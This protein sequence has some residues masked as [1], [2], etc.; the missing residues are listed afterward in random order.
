M[1]FV[2]EKYVGVTCKV[3]EENGVSLKPSL[4]NIDVKKLNLYDEK[5]INIY[6]NQKYLN[7]Y[8]KLLKLVVRFL[9]VED[10]SDES[11]ELVLSEISRIE[12]LL[13]SEYKD[14]VSEAKLSEMLKELY[15][16]G[17]KI[18]RKNQKKVVY[19]DEKNKAR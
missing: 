11:T 17:R 14:F 7:K 16:L 15:N 3:F 13:L 1:E 19:M 6:L 5:I 10:P 4:Q 12:L 2:K 9:E 18:K 8:K